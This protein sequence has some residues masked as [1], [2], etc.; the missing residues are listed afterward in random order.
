MKKKTGFAI[1]SMLSALMLLGSNALAIAP[2]QQSSSN[3]KAHMDVSDSIRYELENGMTK[4]IYSTDDAIIENL[5]VETEADSDRDGKFD[6]ISIKVMRP[7]TEPGIKVPVIYEISPYRSGLNPIN[8]YDV[9]RELN[10]IPHPGNKNGGKPYSNPANLGSYGNYY[11]PRGY[12]V[13]LAESI[14]SGKSDGCPTTGDYN[15][16]LAAKSVIDWLNGRA[17]AYTADGDEVPAGWSTG[18]V[19]MLGVS[20]NGTLPNAVATTGVE[21]L[22]TIVPTAAISNWYDYYRSNG[23]LI[24]PGGYQGEDADV[25]AKAVLTRDNPEVCQQIMDE[26]TDGQDRET[27]DYNEFWEARN[28]L[29]DANKIKASVFIIH[30]LND[31]NVKTKQFDQWW[32][33]LENNNVPR[34]MWL[35]QGGHSGTSTNNFQKT[36]NRWFDHWLYGIENGIMDEPPVEIQREDS[37]WHPQTNW[38]EETA[39]PTTFQLDSVK[40]SAAG[41]LSSKSLPNK[42]NAKKQFIDDPLRRANSFIANPEMDSPNRLVYLTPELTE[43]MRISGTATV[44]LRASIDR[45]V[46]NLTA[47]LVDYSGA[48]PTI[49]TRGW[50][51]PQNS[52]S[53]S[54][55]KWLEPNRDYTFSWD[56]QPDDYVF[57]AGSK[58]GLVLIATDYDYTVRPTAGTKITI[59]PTKSE[60]ILPV[61]G[62]INK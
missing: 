17:K 3:D 42:P 34:K 1:G 16:T 14:G 8:F 31:W 7:A 21:G 19:G 33:A 4:P 12:A 59:T 32:K 27:G 55:S 20:Y 35:H 41:I 58:I 26:I 47:L 37:T 10:P 49:V 60:L 51:D 18:N 53:D 56:M 28:Y 39:I 2:E 11:V 57:K 44:E 5:F 43:P 13:I 24:A 15:E 40:D 23:A 30:G 50:T 62:G 46:A 6:R 52:K 38:P 36:Q 61:V 29:H 45:P 48:T 25:L 54:R 22:K 9:D